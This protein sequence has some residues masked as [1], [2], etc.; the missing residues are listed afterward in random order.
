ASWARIA[1]THPEIRP[2]SFLTGT[3]TLTVSVSSPGSPAPRRCRLRPA[4]PS[5]TRLCTPAASPKAP[6]RAA[7]TFRTVEGTWRL[8][9]PGRLRS[10]PG[11]VGGRDRWD[12]GLDGLGRGRRGSGRSRHPPLH[13]PSPHLPPPPPNP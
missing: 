1:A 12:G 4:R 8:P 13:R 11:R 3:T 2:A 5:R 10:P 6:A 9:L 7:A